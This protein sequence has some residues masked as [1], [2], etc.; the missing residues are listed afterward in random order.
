MP[1][2]VDIVATL[3]VLADHRSSTALARLLTGA[4]WR[5]GPAD[6]AALNRRA[7]SLEP[8]AWRPPRPTRVRVREEDAVN[9]IEALDDLGPEADYSPEGFRRLDLLRRELQALRYRLGVPLPELVAEVERVIGIDIEVAASAARAHIG[10]IHLDRFLDEAARF[11]ADA[12]EATLRAFLAFLEAAE[13]EENGLD[14]GEVEVESER[15]QILTVHGAKGLEWDVVAVPGL[16]DDVFPAPRPRARTGRAPGSCCRRRC[17]VTAT[18]CPRFTIDGA[19]DRR[20]VRDRL[21]PTT[22]RSSTATPTRSGGWPTSR[23]PGRGT[24]CSARAT[25]GATP[26]K[27]AP[28]SVFLDELRT[29]GRGRRLGRR[30]ARRRGEP[31]DD[32][33]P[34]GRLAARPARPAAG[35]RSRP[36]PSWSGPPRGPLPAPARPSGIEG[37]RPART[38]RCSGLLG[39]AAEARSDWRRSVDLLLAE[40]ARLA[41]ADAVEVELPAHLSVSDLV[42]LQRDPDELARRLRRP[43]PSRPAPLARR[44]TAFH[45]WLEQRWS[46]QAL[47]DVDELPGQ[48]RRGGRRQ[49]TSRRSRPRS[50]AAAGPRAPRPRSRSVSR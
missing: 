6:L 8:A 47:L 30:P 50:S 17:A 36:A 20:E 14:V 40:R 1:E 13:I 39:D 46:A 31:A 22:T 42:A 37:A 32:R 49:R 25:C 10:R 38:S 35:R 29:A 21:R 33:R 18:T 15:V 2:I 12:D 44:G 16:V 48:R 26:I 7:R 3:R 41:R 4:R 9:L 23:S 27:P 43:L 28:P 45:A 24:S 11:A 34:V 19:A 5:I